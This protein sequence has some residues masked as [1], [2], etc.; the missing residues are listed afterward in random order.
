MVLV[1][2]RAV[3]FLRWL[4]IFARG[5][6]SQFQ[7]QSSRAPTTHTPCRRP[8]SSLEQACRWLPPRCAHH[9]GIQRNVAAAADPSLS[10]GTA[11]VFPEALIPLS[12]SRHLDRRSSV[13]SDRRKSRVL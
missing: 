4:E 1:F 9:S 5:S 13:S 11:Q 2:C 3:F 8:S 10:S 6:R 7:R 12:L